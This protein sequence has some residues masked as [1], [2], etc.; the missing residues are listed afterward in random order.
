MTRAGVAVTTGDLATITDWLAEQTGLVFDGSHADRMADTVGRAYQGSGAASPGDYIEI[1]QHDPVAYDTLTD[2]LTIGETYFF[3]E[4]R[5]FELLRSRIAPERATL[6]LRPLRVWSAG[7]AS[8]E[9]PYSVAITLAE[10][11]MADGA[12]II[13]TDLSAPALERARR[14]VYGNWSLRRCG[15]DERRAWFRPQGRRFRLRAEYREAV[16]WSARGLLDGPPGGGFDVVLCRNVL[17]YLS[18]G[19]V[20]E[21]AEVL[22]AALVSGGWLLMGASDPPLAHP[23]LE[24]KIG[25]HGIAYRRVDRHR[26]R[27][28][29]AAPAWVPT[30]SPTMATSSPAPRTSAPIR[31]DPAPPPPARPAAAWQAVSEPADDGDDPLNAHLRYRAAVA[32]LEAGDTGGAAREA[33]AA[34]YLDG[35]LIAAHLLLAHLA[36]LDGD[37]NAASRGYR[38]AVALLTELPG[39]VTVELVDEPAGNVLDGVLRR[40]SR[41]EGDR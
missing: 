41:L 30:S 4:P 39:D 5:H 22:H 37:A 36:D 32:H 7:C 25:S 33:S 24:L 35:D 11:G 15:E 34:R 3:R 38:S 16:R 1:L 26:A 9:E 13:G 20:Q 12:T 14:A 29:G 17:I 21:A 18:P 8:G 28:R 2:R 40:L 31:M 27:S 6:H 23:G 19:A 10:A